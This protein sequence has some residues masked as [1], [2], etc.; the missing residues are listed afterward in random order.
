LT[1]PLIADL[2]RRIQLIEAW[3]RGIPL[4]LEKAPNVQQPMILPIDNL[5]NAKERAP[6]DQAIILERKMILQ[7]ETKET[8]DEEIMQNPSYTRK[9]G[10][11]S[12][13][14]RCNQLNLSYL[15]FLL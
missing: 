3:G 1:S 10:E 9:V 5:L 6:G 14:F 11:L 15:R 2:L 4:I 7:E 13:G 8:E 12:P